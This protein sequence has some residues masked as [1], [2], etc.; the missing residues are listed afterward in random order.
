MV[1]H[2]GARP[3]NYLFSAAD[4]NYGGA[5]IT[6]ILL[7]VRSDVGKEDKQVGAK[8]ETVYKNFT[9]QNNVGVQVNGTA[10]PNKTQTY[11]MNTWLILVYRGMIKPNTWHFC[12][13]TT[14]MGW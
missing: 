8:T 3:T 4:E 14:V 7:A 5:G 12:P 10:V 1:E 2:F 13:V 11:P 6:G 9:F